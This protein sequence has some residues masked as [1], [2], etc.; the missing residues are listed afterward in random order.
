MWR[1]ELPADGALEGHFPERCAVFGLLAAVSGFCRGRVSSL[2]C[3]SASCKP[4]HAL[5]GS[6]AL[7]LHRV[8]PV[9]AALSL[10]LRLDVIA[11]S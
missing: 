9:L 1:P 4:G 10:D 3:W 8:S 2:L 5:D 6:D 7:E 11:V